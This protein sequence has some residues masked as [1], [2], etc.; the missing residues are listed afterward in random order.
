MTDPSF[1]PFTAQHV[2]TLIAGGAAIALFL[3]LG[4]RG[5]RIEAATRA[6]L[7]FVCLTATVFT[8]WAWSHVERASDIDNVVPL[9]LCD[10]AAFTA[11]FAL[12]TGHRTLA[13]L[14]YFWGFAGAV[15]AVLTPALDIGCPHPAFWSFFS[16]HFGVIA[17]SLYLPI[18]LGWR[19]ERP[20]WKSPLLA[21]AWLNA[22]VLVAIAANT[23][24]GTNFGFLARKP[25]NPSLLD[26]LGPHPGYILWL[27]VIALV[28]FLL[29]SIAVRP[30]AGRD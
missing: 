6:T 5:G 21:F 16:H 28:S 7:A 20:W 24:L 30:R 13:A 14:T 26:H 15:Q 19:A 18:V 4:R 17:A 9:H 3:I 25:T 8:S 27:E 10:V 23:L 12:L 11:A 22:Y 2:I 29:L 1:V